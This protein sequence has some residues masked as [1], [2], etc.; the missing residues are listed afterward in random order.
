MIVT[1]Q[2]YY[3]SLFKLV[4]FDN[5]RDLV[6]QECKPEEG[7]NLPPLSPF[8]EFRFL[9]GGRAVALFTAQPNVHSLRI[10]I[11]VF[12]RNTLASP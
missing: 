6:L 12:Q 1:I 10:K 8:P 9:P 11:A 4:T 3:S 2:L 7:P 5:K